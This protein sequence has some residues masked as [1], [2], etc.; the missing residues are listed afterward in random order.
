[1]L[2]PRNGGD[3]RFIGKLERTVEAYMTVKIMVLDSL[4]NFSMRYLHRPRHGFG[5]FLGH[6]STERNGL[7]FPVERANDWVGRCYF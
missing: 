6:Y 1:M 4:Y 2:G 3:G 5:N 7:R